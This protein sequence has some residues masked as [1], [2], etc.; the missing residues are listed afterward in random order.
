MVKGHSAPIEDFIRE[1]GKGRIHAGEIL[2]VWSVRAGRTDEACRSASPMSE[3][4]GEL[5]PKPDW[6]QQAAEGNLGGAAPSGLSA[7][8][9][10]KARRD[11]WQEGPIPPPRA[12]R[13]E[14]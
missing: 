11:G 14:R 5:T 1:H 7:T 12:K 3:T 9:I 2:A 13:S 6:K 10:A 8:G 4:S